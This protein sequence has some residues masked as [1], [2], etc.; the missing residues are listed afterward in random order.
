[1]KPTVLGTPLST[2]VPINH[3]A[4]SPSLWVSTRQWS[5]HQLEETSG[6]QPASSPR[7][8]LQLQSQ[9]ADLAL[10]PTGEMWYRSA[11]E[12]VLPVFLTFTL[13]TETPDVVAEIAM[14]H[15]LPPPQIGE[16]ALLPD[17]DGQLL[18][19]HIMDLSLEARQRWA[20]L[21]EMIRT[22]A[23]PLTVWPASNDLYALAS[24]EKVFMEHL[25]DLM[26]RHRDLTVLIAPEDR[27]EDARFSL[28]L[29]MHNLQTAREHLV[30]LRASLEQD[31]WLEQWQAIQ[32]TARALAQDYLQHHQQGGAPASPAPLVVVDRRRSARRASKPAVERKQQ[33][34][35][36]VSS[37]ILN[38]EIIKSL[39]ETADYTSDPARGVAEHKH[40]FA[41]QRGQI[42]ITLHPLQDEGFDTLL[43]ALNTLGDGCVDTYIAVMAMAIERHGVHHL[44]TAFEVSP[45][46]ILDVR[47]KKRSNGSFAPFQRADVVKELKTLSQARVIASMPGPGRKTEIRAEGALIDLLDFKIG[48]YSLIT[49]EE[50]WEQRSIILGKW[51]SMIP[52]LDSQTAVMLRQVLAYSSK[53]ERFQKRLGLHLSIMFR[54]NARHGGQFPKG[55]SLRALLEMSG[56]VLPKKHPADFRAAIEQALACLQ[57]DQVIGKYWQI[58][59]ASPTG[60]ERERAIR[61]QQY[62]W[63]NHWLD[64][65][66]NFAPP[67]R[68][69]QRY[70]KLLPEGNQEG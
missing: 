53:N 6:W 62:G 61:E 5:F 30:M 36:V 40:S 64:R 54:V 13:G 10:S 65:Q 24:D 26:G 9:L 1:M 55:I 46:D 56:I 7:Q 47:G 68:I 43:A 15:P 11:P 50:I 57:R 51:V 8:A 2:V 38:H 70:S 37:N 58:V 20:A 3:R 25:R 16:Y 60:E 14:L 34:M 23:A 28:M 22:L 69:K 59:D 4:T 66:W 19:Y 12:E 48:E 29:Q 49:G 41:K 45:D 67:E 33:D 35:L 31:D 21:G 18:A 32:E 39:R 63:L 42:S 17:E 44:R 27:D 52:E